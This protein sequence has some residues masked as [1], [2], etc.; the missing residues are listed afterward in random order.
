MR[1]SVDTDIETY[2]IEAALTFGA[3]APGSEPP[4]RCGI[5]LGTDTV[6]IA[7]VDEAGRP[8]FHES[9][10]CEAVRDGVVVDTHAETVGAGA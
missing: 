7:V 8:V 3:P 5:D 4:F 6:V 2:L 9:R 10:K 1:A